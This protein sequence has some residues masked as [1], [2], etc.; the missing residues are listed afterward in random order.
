MAY[1]FIGLIGTLLSAPPILKRAYRGPVVFKKRTVFPKEAKLTVESIDMLSLDVY[2]RM[3]DG[4]KLPI[5][6]ATLEGPRAWEEIY[7]AAGSAGQS[8]ISSYRMEIRKGFG[9]HTVYLDV[10]VK[11][12]QMSSEENYECRL[13]QSS[14]GDIWTP[15]MPLPQGETLGF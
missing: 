1:D 15:D 8:N 11:D 6:G 12:T 9:R 3:M 2:M 5:L 10:L 13:V 14:S 7:L 4:G